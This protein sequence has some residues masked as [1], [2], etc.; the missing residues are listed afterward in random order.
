[1]QV[2]SIDVLP[3]LEA[4]PFYQRPLAIWEK[5]LGS[6]HLQVA[7]ILN[8][9]VVFYRAQGRYSVSVSHAALTYEPR[10]GGAF[11]SISIAF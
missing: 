2:R 10:S 9:M 5:A 3:W 1:M 11:L 7:P 8:N 4:A 6:K